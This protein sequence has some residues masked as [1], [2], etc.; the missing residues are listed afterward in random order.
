MTLDLSQITA[1]MLYVLL[2][3]LAITVVIFIIHVIFC[4]IFKIDVDSCM[5]TL[6]A[7]I[8]GPAFIPALTKQMKNDNITSAGLICGSVGYAVGTFLG[9][10]VAWLL[11][12]L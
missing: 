2:F 5:V 4:K 1:N 10:G 8:Y 11:M 6:A 3:Y 7:G 9:V 12:L